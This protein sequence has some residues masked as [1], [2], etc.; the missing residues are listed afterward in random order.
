MLGRNKQPEWNP[1]IHH[2]QCWKCD[3]LFQS[4]FITKPLLC[5]LKV[6][7]FLTSP[8]FS[9]LIFN[10]TSNTRLSH[11]QFANG[12][13][14]NFQYSFLLPCQEKTAYAVPLPYHCLLHFLCLTWLPSFN[15]H[16]RS[17]CLLPEIY[18]TF[19]C[20][21]P[22]ET[23]NKECKWLQMISST[24]FSPVLANFWVSRKG[25]LS[26]VLTW[27]GICWDDQ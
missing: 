11:Y 16:P 12:S 13:W 25:L 10:I 21:R 19:P 20:S 17:Y 2:T 22:W 1:Q 7:H 8:Y 15:I 24:S 18:L 6:F 9:S 14:A 4:L 5:V 26:L 27:P 3:H 23:Y